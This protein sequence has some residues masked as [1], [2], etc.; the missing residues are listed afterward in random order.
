MSGDEITEI[1]VSLATLE[2]MLQAHFSRDD[3]RAQRWEA[4]ELRIQTLEGAEQR[5]RG[6]AAMLTV[7]AGAAATLGGL[8]AK[9]FP[10][11]R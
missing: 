7:M 6:G 1:K 2:T 4:H 11:G 9:F 10:L 8:I 5:R 3:E